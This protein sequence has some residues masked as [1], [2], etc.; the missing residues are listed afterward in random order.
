VCGGMMLYLPP[1]VIGEICSYVYI[2][3]V[4]IR[5]INICR[6]ILGL[7][8]VKVVIEATVWRRFL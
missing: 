7:S 5:M 8:L 3:N 1:R 6:S 2:E 4:P